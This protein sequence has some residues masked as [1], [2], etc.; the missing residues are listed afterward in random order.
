MGEDWVSLDGGKADVVQE[1]VAGPSQGTQLAPSVVSRAHDLPNTHVV[2]QPRTPEGETPPEG[3]PPSGWG[4]AMTGGEGEASVLG[5]SL[6]SSAAAQAAGATAVP[7]AEP[8]AG[9]GSLWGS[10]NRW[11]SLPPQPAAVIS[12]WE[13]EEEEGGE[14]E[15][16]GEEEEEEGKGVVQVVEGG[17]EQEAEEFGGVGDDEEDE[18]DEADVGVPLDPIEL[19]PSAASD[20]IWN[21]Q[22]LQDQ[23]DAYWEQSRRGGATAG[24]PPRSVQQLS[25]YGSGEPHLQP[26]YGPGDWVGGGGGGALLPE[27]LPGSAAPHLF[28]GGNQAPINIYGNVH[29]HLQQGGGDQQQQQQQQQGGRQGRPS[30]TSAELSAR[31]RYYSQGET[32]WS[33]S[34]RGGQ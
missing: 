23:L 7:E 16:K 22:H 25:A 1:Q 11:E 2:S 18:G 10:T 5:G 6:R 27:P 14:G 29:V 15:G 17:E 33:G 31:E 34:E 3:T 30:P 4:A 19:P 9:S 13:G 32:S 26:T 24:P 12:D 21:D 28:Q 8:A 20:E